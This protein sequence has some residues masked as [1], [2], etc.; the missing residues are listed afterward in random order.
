MVGKL[1]I[2]LVVGAAVAAAAPA[3]VETKNALRELLNGL[4]KRQCDGAGANTCGN[5]NCYDKREKCD[6]IND[7]GDFT[8]ETGCDK[9][10]LGDAKCPNADVCVA[11]IKLCDGAG[12][13]CP[14]G[15]DEDAGFCGGDYCS[16]NPGTFK[17]S[18]KA[19]LNAICA[20]CSWATDSNPGDCLGD[21]EANSGCTGKR[22]VASEIDL[23]KREL[24][25]ALLLVRTMLK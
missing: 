6:G 5:G 1:L 2:L 18:V 20:P 13:A 23:K 12:D 9:C 17:C 19:G 4:L 24:E 10:Q 7:C 3:S 22:W 16:G 14:D 25:K 15:A 8:D 21:E 11:P